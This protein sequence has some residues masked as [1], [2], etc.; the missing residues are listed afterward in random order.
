VVGSM[1]ETW[2]IYYKCR[3][4]GEVYSDTKG[5]EKPCRDGVMHAVC[6]AVPWSHSVGVPPSMTD[7]HHCNDKQVGVADLIGTRVE[8]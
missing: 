2:G 1:S 4:C 7:L 5:G 3:L 8:L 6:P